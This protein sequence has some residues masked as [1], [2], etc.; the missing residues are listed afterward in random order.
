LPLQ[1]ACRT[2]ENLRMRWDVPQLVIIT[3]SAE[4]HD[5]CSF[6]LPAF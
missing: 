6:R 5:A 4:E 2:K 1:R 3:G